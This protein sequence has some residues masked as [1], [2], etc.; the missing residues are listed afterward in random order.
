MCEG[1]RLVGSF[2]PCPAPL[3]LS[4]KLVQERRKLHG[5]RIG[6]FPNKSCIFRAERLPCGNFSPAK[7]LF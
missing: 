6:E 4:V 1:K 2:S 3:G 7:M 5:K